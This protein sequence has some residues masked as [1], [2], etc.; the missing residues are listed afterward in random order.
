MV[1][2]LIINFIDV[3][4]NLN[5]INFIIVALNLNEIINFGFTQMDFI[6]ND[7]IIYQIMHFND[8]V[9]NFHFIHFDF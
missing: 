6:L 1:F 2:I 4:F 3:D 5:K 8:F 7:N 9:H